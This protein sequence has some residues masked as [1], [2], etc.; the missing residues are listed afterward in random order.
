VVAS[1]RG[2]A[3]GRPSRMTGSLPGVSADQQPAPSVNVS[4]E[5]LVTALPHPRSP[6]HADRFSLGNPNFAGA[7]WPRTGERTEGSPAGT[8]PVRPSARTPCCRA[9]SHTERGL[10]ANKGLRTRPGTTGSEAPPVGSSG[11][12]WPPASTAVRRVTDGHL[13]L[14][15]GTAQHTLQPGQCSMGVPGRRRRSRP[16]SGSSRRRIRRV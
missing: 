3:R 1:P 6:D 5:P 12:S 10:S 8:F 16:T 9:A 7:G 15:E 13:G 14:H 4:P 2:P 11:L